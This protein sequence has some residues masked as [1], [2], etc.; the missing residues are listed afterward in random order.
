MY[1]IG[2][3][4]CSA[5]S[6]S[7]NLPMNHQLINF[8]V[9]FLCLY[10]LMFFNVNVKAQNPSNQYE[11]NS[12]DAVSNFQPSLAVVI[13]ILSIMFS[14]TLMLLLYAKYCHRSAS[15]SVHN[16]HLQIQDGLLR[17]R[18]RSSSS[19]GI[20][21]TVIESLPFFRF[22]SLK[23]SREGLECS[24]CL[25]RFEDVEILRLL[26]KCKHGFHIDCLDQWLE[27]HSSCPLCRNKVSA[28]DDLSALNYSNSL[29]FLWNIQSERKEDSGIELYIQREGSRRGSS[30]SSSRFSSFRRTDNKDKKKEEELPI[31]IQIHQWSSDEN[32]EDDRK[33]LHKFNHRI[34]VSDVVLKHRWSNVS[35]SD[36]M[37][38]NSEML[39]QISS[40]RFSE[41]GI[42]REQSA[43]TKL[44]GDGEIVNLKEEM[45]RKREFESKLQSKMKQNIVESFPPP[46]PPPPPGKESETKAGNWENSSKV[47]STSDK[48]SMSEITVHSRF[49][50]FSNRNTRSNGMEPSLPENTVKEERI[51]KLWL[52]IA[53]RTVEWFANR[54]RRTPSS[55][56]TRQPSNV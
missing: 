31:Q 52:P 37:F 11:Y 10:H 20:E 47:L 29:R 28:D 54:E 27:K 30:S 43:P 38:L 24:I 48:R 17:E 51:R 7:F 44:A 8:Y 2:A 35:S 36:L 56:N 4:P 55:Q 40:N 39:Q 13:G 1:F 16:H 18:S 6:S 46:P 50:D 33:A 5:R 9:F 23:G 32:Y 42:N 34:V 12:E 19:S 45:G 21:K 15:S 41:L 3:A 53:R 14:L 25:S 22:S 49:Q 26:P